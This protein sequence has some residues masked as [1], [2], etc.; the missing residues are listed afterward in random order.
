MTTNLWRNEYDI[1]VSLF[2]SLSLSGLKPW[3]D[4]CE[5]ELQKPLLSLLFLLP[6]AALA[7]SYY[8]QLGTNYTLSI[9][10]CNS[11]IFSFLGKDDKASPYSLVSVGGYV[12]FT[13]IALWTK[14]DLHSLHIYILPAGVGIL[15]LVQ[16]LKDKM[17]HESRR[18]VR[19]VTLLT[20][21]G[22]TAYYALITEPHSV[23]FNVTMILL[24]VV[25][26]GTGSFFRIRLYLSIGFAGLL[27]NILAILVRLV[28]DMNKGTR[29]AI[30]GS[31]ILVIGSTLVFAN[32]YYK[33]HQE[34][35]KVF[36]QKWRDKFGLWE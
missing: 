33:T 9:I 15:I 1:W 34:K 3:I 36:V 26:M 22:T 31:L 6:F 23:G 5:K 19:L 2:I 13:M 29:M 4:R 20:M 17:T 32:L 21:V 18:G 16:L 14:L 30:L 12:A 7:W 24:C 11:L 25:V 10:G 8:H 28:T 35:I 27:V